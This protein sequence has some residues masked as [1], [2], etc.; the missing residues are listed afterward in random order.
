M[1]KRVYR[2]IDEDRTRL[3]DQDELFVQ[4]GR[5]NENYY[6]TWNQDPEVDVCP[7]CG[8]EVPQR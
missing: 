2:N 3:L 7:R 5:G 8:G 6:V 1:P 4:K